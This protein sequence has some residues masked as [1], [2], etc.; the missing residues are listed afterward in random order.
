MGAIS[1]PFSM[2][3][4][5]SFS[6]KNFL[7]YLKFVTGFLRYSILMTISFQFNSGVTTMNFFVLFFQLPTSAIMHL[8]SE[9]EKNRVLNF[10][11]FKSSRKSN[12]SVKTSVYRKPIFTGLYRSFNS[13][14]P[15]SY[16]INLVET[17]ASCARQ[18]CT[19]NILTLRFFY[20]QCSY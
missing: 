14:F 12:G 13:F 6:V 3:F 10:L 4:Y 7:V 9:A 8:T 5:R 19:A 1:V 16:K 20:S 2:I 11:D 18:A 15:C 17:L